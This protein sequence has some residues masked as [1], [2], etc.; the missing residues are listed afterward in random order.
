MKSSK[1]ISVLLAIVLA[2]FALSASI[3]VPI[4]FRS[5]YYAQIDSLALPEQTG[6]SKDVIRQAYDE[7]MDYLVFGA[8]FGTGSLRS[9]AD[10]QAHFADCRALFRLDFILLGVSTILLIALTVWRRRR[11]TT[12]Y[13]LCGHSAVF[14]AAAGLSAIFLLVALWAVIDF[15]SLFTAFHH[16]FFPGK[17]NWVFDWRTDEI[18]LIL[19]E[20]FWM[21]TGAFVLVLCL[22]GLWITAFAVWAACRWRKKLRIL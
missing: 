22:G 10:G 5:F 20:A 18:I 1:A 2:V 4:L 7:V 13:H 16:A 6:W 19:P 15:S 14:W 12:F 8:P 9:S 3:A 17:T 21:R 11:K